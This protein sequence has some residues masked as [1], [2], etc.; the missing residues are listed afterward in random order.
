MWSSCDKSA[1]F[2]ILNCLIALSPTISPLVHLSLSRCSEIVMML[3]YTLWLQV[4]LILPVGGS[5]SD[6][7]SLSSTSFISHTHTNQIWNDF[8]KSVFY[9]FVSV[10]DVMVM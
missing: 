9:I 5:A 2:G 10:F 4:V 1:V 7:L 6:R 8:L 3:L